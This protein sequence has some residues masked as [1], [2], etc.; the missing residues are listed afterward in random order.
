MLDEKSLKAIYHAHIYSH[1]SYCIVVWGSMLNAEHK[2]NLYK[3][4]KACIRTVARLKPRDSLHG[5]F[6]ALR[7]LTFPDMIKLELAKLGFKVSNKHLPA[8]SMQMEEKRNINTRP[9]IR[10][11]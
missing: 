2:E 10:Q 9:G 6:S 7:A 5:V 4:Q 3:A 1:L 8:T 11:S